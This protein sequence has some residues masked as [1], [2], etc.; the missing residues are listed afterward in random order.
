MGTYPNP[1]NVPTDVPEADDLAQTMEE[2]WKEVESALRQSKQQMIAGEEGSPEEFEIGEEA[3]LDAKNVNLKTLSPK[4]TKQQLGPFKVIEKISNRA[5]Q[6]E[7]PPTMRIH[8]VF[9]VGLLS[10]VKRD[11]KRAFENQPPPVTVD[12]EEEYKVEGITD[13][14]KRGKKWFFRVKWKGY[15]SEENTWEPRENLKNAEKS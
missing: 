4:L 1:S 3:W 8:N 11:S 6:L 5:Y 2:Q 12:G 7:L 14:E 13:M 9:Y 15:G 10:K